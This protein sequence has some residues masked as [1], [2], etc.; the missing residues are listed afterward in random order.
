MHATRF[1]IIGVADWAYV[2]PKVLWSQVIVSG[3]VFLIPQRW[4]L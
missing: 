1:A 2:I 4:G 3:S